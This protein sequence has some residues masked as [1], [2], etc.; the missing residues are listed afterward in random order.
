MSSSPIHMN[1]ASFKE[2]YGHYLLERTEQ[3]CMQDDELCSFHN[4]IHLS[5]MPS[6]ERGSSSTLFVMRFERE[7]K[8]QDT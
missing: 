6:K 3:I 7:F 8:A 1:R 5:L 4:L 2:H